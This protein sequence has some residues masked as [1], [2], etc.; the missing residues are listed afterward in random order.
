NKV[1]NSFIGRIILKIIAFSKDFRNNISTM[2]NKVKNKFTT[3]IDSIRKSIANSFVGRMLSSVRNLKTKFIDLAGDMWQGVK[4]QFNNIVDGA[5][6]VPKRIGDGIKNAKSKATD[7]M[8]AVGNKLIEWA[9]KPYNKVIGGVNWITDKLGI[10]KDIKKWDWKAKQYAK[11]TGLGGHRGG[12]AILGD[13]VG[14]NAGSELVQL[15]SGQQFMSASTP[16][17]Y[18]NL[19]KGTEVLSATNTRDYL[20]SIPMYAEGTN[21]FNKAWEGIKG[22]GSKAKDAITGIWDYATKPKKLLDKLLKG[23]NLYQD[24]ARVPRDIVKGGFG[25]IKDVAVDAVKGFFTEAES[26]GGEGGKPNFPYPITSRFGRRWGRNHNGVDFGFPHGS[27]VKSQTSGKVK[28]AGWYGGYGKAVTVKSGILDIIYAHISSISKK[29]GD[30]VTKGSKIGLSG[31]T[32][33]STGPHLHYEVRKNGVPVDPLKLSSD[34]SGVGKY[35]GVASKALRMTGNYSKKNLD[36]LMMQMKSE[37]NG[38]PNAI[39]NWDINA[40]RGTPSKGLMQ[41]IDPTFQSYKMKGYNDIWKP[42]DNILASIR[43][44]KATYGSLTRA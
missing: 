9:G 40:K 12:H 33:N 44:A 10:K 5:K 11:G 22:A 16:T 4:K 20:S 31:N 7:G 27:T 15:P 19:P 32:G 41:V 42:L 1:K 35:R 23:V 38:N 30:K 29:V 18:P 28:Q 25:T 37:S 17:L 3:F 39:N 34:V 26:F 21:W 43:Y 13:G 24:K 14:S 6:K 8:K 2:W 36:A